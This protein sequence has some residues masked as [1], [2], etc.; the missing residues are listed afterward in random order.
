MSIIP[1]VDKTLVFK[2]TTQPEIE[3]TIMSLESKTS[4]GH[5]EISNSLLKKLCH[6]ISFPL[7]AIFNQSLY[8]GKFS[9]QIKLAKIIPLYKGKESDQAINYKPISLLITISKVFEKLGYTQVY[10]FLELNNVLYENQYGFRNKRSCKQAI[11]DLISH[12]LQAKKNDDHTAALFFDLS[13]V[14]DMLNH[15]MLLKNLDLYGLRGIINEWFEDY[16]KN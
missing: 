13:K 8:E 15:I 11:L 12:V 1:R 10:G 7:C 4:F 6:S 2:P 5:D 16:L 3:R 9:S 14:F